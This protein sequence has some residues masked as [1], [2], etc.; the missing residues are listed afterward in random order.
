MVLSLIREQKGLKG[1]IEWLE[2]CQ[3]NRLYNFINIWSSL[4]L[5][6]ISLEGL[7]VILLGFKE[8]WVKLIWQGFSGKLAKL[9]LKCLVIYVLWIRRRV[10]IEPFILS[11]LQS[12]I[13]NKAPL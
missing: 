3:F 10:L 2:I 13:G 11:I 1:L 4:L 9:N 6:G 5:V 7:L 12:K 8:S